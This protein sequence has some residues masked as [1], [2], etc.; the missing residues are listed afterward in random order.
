MTQTPWK[1]RHWVSKLVL[2]L[3]V[4]A[5][6]APSS[7]EAQS[8]PASDSGHVTDVVP[9]PGQPAFD[10]T[11]T[12]HF[13]DANGVR[14]HYVVGGTGEP[15]V[16]LHGWAQTWYSW[17][18]VM[19]LL[20]DAGYQVIVPDLRGMGDSERPQGG[21]DKKTVSAD[22]VALM[23]SL[24]H[25]RFNVV[26]HDI[27]AQVAYALARH[28]GEHVNKLVVMDA[29]AP[30]IPPWDELTRNPA[31]WHWSFYNVADL[32]EALIGGRERLYFTWFYHQIASDIAATDADIDEVVRAYSKPGALRGGLAYFR[33]FEQDARDNADYATHRL[34]MPVLALGGAA[35]GAGEMPLNQ[36][37][38]AATD[39]TGGTIE[40]SGHWIQIERPRALSDRII[41]FLSN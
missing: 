28:H 15:V 21:Y 34:R 41:T 29:P 26:G 13:A 12:H 25:D 1:A 39:V 35:N 3:A 24:G 33:A 14:L 32:P 16:L 17:R 18:R 9:G 40:G 20:V 38:L 30:G 37:R 19:P 6:L 4:A 5:S 10:A 7:V 23:A 8:R 36:M 22:I 27:G 2:I 31:L 11:F